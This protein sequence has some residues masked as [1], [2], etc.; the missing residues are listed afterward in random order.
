MKT[1]TLDLAAA[2]VEALDHDLRAALA[3]HFYGL[4]Y[5]GQTATLVL[6]ETVTAAELKQA[7]NIVTAHDP[8]S[9]S[10]DQQ[11][12]ILQ[13][14]KLEQA[15][16]AYAAAELDLSAYQGKDALLQALAQKVVWLEREIHAL[17]KT[18]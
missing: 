12:D 17:H 14:A 7:Q 4:T 13:T 11:A 2:N 10:P 5:D 1:L 3:N 16:Q 9:L 18:I 6:D 15:R 8:A